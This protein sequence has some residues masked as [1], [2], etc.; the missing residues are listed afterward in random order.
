MDLDFNACYRAVTSRDGRFDGRFW[1]GVLSTKIYCRPSCP[2]RTPGRARVR[3]YAHP[4]LA[5]RDGFRACR[6]C[7]PELSPDAPDWD[8]RGDLIGRALRL[9]AAGVVD[10]EGVAGLAARLAVG[11][12]HLHRQFVA[13]LGT[14]PLV[15]ARTR[16]VQLARQLLDQTDLPV[17]RVAFAAGFGS[18]RQF[19]DALRSTYDRT[20]TQ[21]RERHAHDRCQGLTLRLGFRAPLDS[22]ALLGFL[23]DRA[24]PGV[25][26]VDAGRYRR[27]IDM[28]DLQITPA[29]A[30]VEL[31]LDVDDATRV[32]PLVQRARRMLDLDADPAAV[33]AVLSGDPV[34]RP[35]IHRRPG[36]RLPG[37]WD[38]FEM[39]VRAIV[40]QQVSVAAAR[41]IAGRLAQ[42]YGKP[43]DAPRRGICVRFPSAETIADADLDGIGMPRT[44]VAA[45]RDLARAV[46]E[47]R[48]VL[49]GSADPDEVVMT[50]Q[51]LHGVG[52]W[53]VA[54]IALRAL[55]DPDAFPSGD[56][57]LRRAFERA[58][59]PADQRS[60]ERHAERWRPWRGYALLHLWTEGSR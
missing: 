35:L 37:A 48:L 11:E 8:I 7:R 2:A 10:A 54:E 57:G 4:A 15:V 22:E 53:T 1:T 36:L 52:P 41:T 56:L 33:N 25:E 45:L 30:A 38:G 46:A 19:N 16:R 24:M 28:G 14:S 17:T 42:R 13:E 29:D 26:A 55:R 39:A 12:R 51:S 20:P 27:A 44:R 47:G 23:A 5:E 40:G 18:V 32:A 6:R 49:D 60:I 59:L 3:F 21:L 58:G 9:I 50:L 31:R 34:L 43:L